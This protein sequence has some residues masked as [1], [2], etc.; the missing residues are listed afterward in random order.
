LSGKQDTH[1]HEAFARH[2]TAQTE[3]V[4]TPSELHQGDSVD[5]PEFTEG[6][7][8]PANDISRRGV[9]RAIC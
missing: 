6:V 8:A 3:F 9:H 5:G 4:S 2:S 7:Q 1:R